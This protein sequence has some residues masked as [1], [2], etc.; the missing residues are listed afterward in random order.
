MKKLFLFIVKIFIAIS[1]LFS[2]TIFGILLKYKMDL[3][4]LQQL[5]EDYKPSTPTVIYDRNDKI[6]DTLYIESREIARIKEIPQSVKDAF[7]AIEDKKFYSHKGI[8]VKGILRAILVN[9]LNKKAS[10]GGSSITQQLAKNAFLSSERTLSRKIK[11]LIITFEL[12]RTYTKD[13]ILEKY[14]NEI[15]F[16]SGSYGVKTAAKQ[17]F[18]K[19]IE[20]INIAEAALLAGIPNRPNK[21]NPVKNLDNALVR[22]K[23]ILKEMYDDNRI[24]KEEYDEALAHKF[25]LESNNTKDITNTTI[26][27]DNKTKNFYKNP[28]FTAIV[29]QY[30][31]TVFE[32]NETYSGGLKVYTTLDLDFQKIARETFDSYSF[33]KN[34]NLEGAMVTLDPFTGG[35]VSIV[36][37]KE[38]KAKNFDRALMAS[39]QFGS[40]FK[41]FLYLSSLDNGFTPYSVVVDNF[42]SFGKWT[43]KNYGGRYSGNSTLANSLNLSIN[44]PAIKL[45]DSIGVQNF[46]EEINSLKFN[47][48]IKDLTASLGSIDGTPLNLAVNFSIFVNGGYLIE[49]NVIREIKDSQDSIVYVANINKDKIFDSVKTSVITSMLKNVVASGTGGRAKVIDKNGLPIEQGGKTGTTNE[50][51][52]IWYAGIT[53]EYVTTIYI[54]RDDNKPIPG[55]ISGGGNVAPLWG[56]YYQTLINKDLYSPGK[57]EFLASHLE[58][59]DL[60]KQNIDII[61]GLLDG[62]NSKEILT[63]KGRIQVESSYKYQ[64]GIASIFGLD[65]QVTSYNGYVP[66]ITDEN[67]EIIENS[68]STNIENNIEHNNDDLVNRLLGD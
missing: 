12:E 61:S 26:I 49:P 63:E 34:E 32:D 22:Q 23:V 58:A 20:D 66:I 39:R 54:G 8:H 15:Y 11:E 41:P 48:E 51:R 7:M 3:P 36:G 38:F 59:G 53:P 68:G 60:I 25:V 9:V 1:I 33:F 43:P 28:E 24:T 56:K 46:K 42:I 62:N 19:D 21:Y 31:Q 45:L 40:T 4:N 52:S 5:V 35:I 37:G 65:S 29:E 6:V 30:L 10:Q 55:R 44:I 64:N 67:G 17:F 50:N 18:N 14:L 57:F 13:E 16:G 2:I 47:G 27:Y